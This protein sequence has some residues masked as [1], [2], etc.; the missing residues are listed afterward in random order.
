MRCINFDD[1]FADYVAAWS[2]AHAEDYA[3]FDDMEEDMPNVY[4]RF[5]NE[6]A[7]WLNGVTPGAYFTQYE[8]PK[9]LVDWLI[10]YTARDIPVPDLL[11]EQ[12]K[13]V[14]K[15]CEKRLVTLLKE[16]NVPQEALMTAVGLLRE[17][18]SEQPKMLY[19]SWQME[20]KDRDELADNAIDS[21]KQMGKCAIQPILEAVGKANRAG[22]EAL[23]DVLADYPGD[24]RVFRLAL[25]LFR[26]TPARQALLASYLGK[27]GDERAIP[28]LKAAAEAEDLKYLDY[29][30]LRNAI[31]QLGGECPEREFDRDPD[32]EAL[33]GTDTRRRGH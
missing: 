19:I 27:L 6:P 1:H 23:L 15:P 24:E 32:Y 3:S 16:E 8:D 14:G 21:L 9:L 2:T 7:K 30:E 20:R 11:L 25:K 29:I 5:L 33:F 13:Y 17:M 26:E 12:I 22:Q 28:T 4:I 31:E 10:E 18:E